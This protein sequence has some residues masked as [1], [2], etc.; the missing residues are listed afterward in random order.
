MTTFYDS[1]E[2]LPQDEEE[3]KKTTKINDL[4]RLSTPKPVMHLGSST[5][6]RFFF[7]AQ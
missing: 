3:L 4:A 7:I 6:V 1:T 5:E 2:F